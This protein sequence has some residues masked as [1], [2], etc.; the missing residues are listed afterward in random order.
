SDLLAACDR[1]GEKVGIEGGGTLRGMGAP[2]AADVIVQTTKLKA[3]LSHEHADL[4]TSVQ[5]GM[6]LG[7]FFDSLAS[8]G[9]FVPLDAPRRRAATIGGTLA[10]GWLGPRRHLFG[11]GRDYVIGT[12]IV[13]AD[14]TIA[15]A[16]GMVVKN[17]T[18]Y[19]MSKLYVG[20]FGTLGVLTQANFKTLPMPPGARA[21]VA[22]LPIQTRARAIDRLQA[23]SIP[24]S[25]ALVVN[26][27][28]REIDGE[29]ADDGRLVVLI[30]GSP[31]LLERA[32]RELRSAL[33][34]AGVPETRIIDA[35]AR[36]AFERTL[37]AYVS[38][39]AERSITYRVLGDP[40]G[41]AE[42]LHGVCAL[43]ERFELKTDL[44][45]DAM[46]GD[47]IVRVRD[48]NDRAFSSKIEMFDDALHD[49]EPRAIVIAGD[50]PMRPILNLWGSPPAA[51]AQMR[52]IKARFDP[53][54]TL[55][56]GRFVGG[57]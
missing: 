8:A 37:D 14:G 26:G 41:L 48:D 33:G 53:N 57:I 34:K 49:L 2:P 38:T 32:T 9:Q 36:D 42:C 44:I 1:A 19:D 7:K 24:P 30:E 6:T 31:A 35:G 52:A 18:G 56:P 47:A 23:L 43:A 12:Q 29:D 17:V 27:Y 25:A 54:N 16:G 21:F 55:N 3:I 20:S 22:P 50:A 13:L 40:V 11:R 39:V 5:A 46:N 4:T 10:A 15:K 28:A 45:G 51:L